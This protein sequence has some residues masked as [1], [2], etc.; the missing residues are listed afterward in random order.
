MQ[1]LAE[2]MIYY[3]FKLFKLFFVNSCVNEHNLARS[4]FHIEINLGCF[5]VIHILKIQVSGLENGTVRILTK[6]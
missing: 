4:A 2:L 1:F 6:I 5:P 3:S